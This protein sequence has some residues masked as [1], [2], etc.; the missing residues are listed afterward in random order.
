[1]SGDD[2]ALVLQLAAALR[3]RGLRIATAESCR[4]E[5]LVRARLRQLQQCRQERAARR[6][7]TPDRH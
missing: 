3:A 6:R 4:L 2:E 1:M 5:R 7:G